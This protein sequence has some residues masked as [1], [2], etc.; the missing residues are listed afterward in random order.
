MSWAWEYLPDAEHVAGGFPADF[1]AAVELRAA[2]LVRAAEVLYLEGASYE[3]SGE[4]MRHL[5][6]AGGLLSYYVVPRL[7]LVAICQLTAPPGA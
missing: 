6:V 7:E 5:D 1:L 3:G 4:P 2:E